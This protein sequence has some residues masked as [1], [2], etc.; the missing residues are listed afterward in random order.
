MNHPPQILFAML[1][2]IDLSSLRAA[3]HIRARTR[4]VAVIP[5]VSALLAANAAMGVSGRK[6]SVACSLAVARYLDA[7]GH[8]GP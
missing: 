3:Y 1:Q 2:T 4:E 7:I 6:D 8:T 5:D